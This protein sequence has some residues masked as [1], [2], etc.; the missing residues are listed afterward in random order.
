MRELHTV[1]E[2]DATADAVWSIL[3]DFPAYDQWNPFIRRV[4][5]SLVAGG[6]IEVRIQ[7]S[8][9]RGMTFRPKLLVIDPPRELRWL[10]HLLFPGIF[11]GEHR[12]AIHPLPGNRVR[13]EQSERFSGLLVPLFAGGIERDTRRGF[14]EMNSALKQ[15]AELHMKYGAHRG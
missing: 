13:F 14:T 7:A 11:D 6:S 3:A 10:G 12:F 9:T 4:K 15:R 2:I 8:G 1:I 5:G